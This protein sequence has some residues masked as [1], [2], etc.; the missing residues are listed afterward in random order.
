MTEQ[1][2]NAFVCYL[3]EEEG[4]DEQLNE[5]NVPLTAFNM[6]EELEEG[7]FDRQGNFIWTE[8]KEIR[9][10]WLDNINWSHVKKATKAAG[11]MTTKGLGEESD[12]G[13]E[14]EHFDEFKVYKELLVYMQPNE[15]V[16][17]TIRRLGGKF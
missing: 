3:G 4:T 15:T 11:S 14:E 6:R 10:E 9:D 2:I 5:G 13:G 12:S 1:C 8:E 16:N 17:K 7:H